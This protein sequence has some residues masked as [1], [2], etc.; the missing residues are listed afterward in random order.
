MTLP[1]PTCYFRPVMIRLCY[2]DVDETL[3]DSSR[4]IVPEL[5]QALARCRTRG[6]GLGL[7]TGRMYESALPYARAI[8]ANAPLILCNGGRIQGPDSGEVLCSRTL[9]RDE[10]RRA[11]RLVKRHGLHVNVYY[12]DR[13]YIEQESETSRESAEKDGV[14]QTPVGDLEAFLD[15]DPMK[16]LIIGPGEKLEALRADY[17]AAPHQSE[18]VRSE[19]TYLEVLPEGVSKGSAL[20][21][22][23]RLTGIPLSQIAAFGDSNN[24]LELLRTAGLGI[25]VANA[26]PQAKAAADRTTTLPFGRGVA[27]QLERFLAD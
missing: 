13:I 24:D 4:R 3:V 26:L 22:V 7:A 2:F 23:S 20:S 21:E 1:P 10:A 11:L 17:E 18:V 9:A 14:V 16:L 6:I 8:G 12:R 5:A 25:A 19:P 15:G 27:E